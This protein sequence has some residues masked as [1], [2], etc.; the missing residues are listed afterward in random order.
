MYTYTHT[1]I[2]MY[3]RT[4]IQLYINRCIDTYKHMYMDMLWSFAVNQ[5]GLPLPCPRPACYADGAGNLRHSFS[6][7]QQLAPAHSIST[8]KEPRHRGN[9]LPSKAIRILGP[10]RA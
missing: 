5:P 10:I 9:R 6:F 2:H 7:L 4:Y 8:R 3:V 1:Y